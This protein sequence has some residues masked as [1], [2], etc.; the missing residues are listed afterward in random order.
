MSSPHAVRAERLPLG[1]GTWPLGG[2]AYGPV[3]PE[4]A[5]RALVRA[6]R[7]GVNL[8]DTA[9][10]Y[11]GGS[12]ERLVGSAVPA[13]AEV[14]GKVG[15]LTESGDGQDF[16][17]AHVLRATHASLRRLA[18]CRLDVLLLHSP[19][20]TTLTDSAVR[21]LFEDVVDR[22]WAGS[23][24]VSLR[25]VYDAE[26]ALDWPAVRT[27]EVIFSAL[28]QRPVDLGLV[29]ECRRR[30]I[31]VLARLP[32]CSGLLAGRHLPGRRFGA[33][34]RRSRWPGAQIDAWL[35]AAG[36]VRHLTDDG[37]LLRAAIQFLITAGVVPIPG[38]KTPA[39][40]DRIVSAARSPAGPDEYERIRDLWKLEL[41]GLPPR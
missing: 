11:G 7:L 25:S 20:R 21:S 17:R 31:R 13:T 39:Q 1:F 16:G 6:V 28:D 12:V 40:V 37:D 36:R 33:H 23:I 26:V 22:G 10:I 5:R 24:G 8:F 2:T 14:V 41:T 27:I 15:Y 3:P 35:E 38:M 18:P 4:V 30:G 19:D 32:L 34:D 29:D 9:D